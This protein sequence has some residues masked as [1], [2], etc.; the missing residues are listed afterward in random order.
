MIITNLVVAQQE[1]HYSQYMFNGLVINP[2]YAGSSD[3]ISASAF[4]RTQWVGFD[5]HPSTQTFSI[6]SP[7]LHKSVG[8]GLQLV[9]DKIGIERKTSILTSYSYKVNVNKG[10]LSMGLQAG[11]QNYSIDQ[12]ELDVKDLDDQKFY[13]SVSSKIVPDFGFGAYY[14]KDNYYIGVSIPHLTQTKLEINGYSTGSEF[15][16]LSRHYFVTA[17]YKYRIN[18]DF[19]VLPSFIFKGVA[20]A[21]VS[22]DLTTHIKY[23]KIAW[24]GGSYRIGDSFN[25]Q[26]GADIGELLD[27]VDKSVRIGYA[28]DLTTSK[29]NSYNNGTHEIML[30]YDFELSP[31]VDGINKK[32]HYAS[33][34]LF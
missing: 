19:S 4:H 25:F 24:F 16:K 28:Y 3:M 5:G 18:R 29:F 30:I 32:T 20:A 17:A 9:N 34:R 21:P 22:L 10:I 12:D 2:A 1:Q 31:K 33:P 11:L 27:K 6:H 14:L 8:L 13:P 15:S 7:A 23:R 26:A